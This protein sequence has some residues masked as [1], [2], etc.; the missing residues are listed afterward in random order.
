[1]GL[2]RRAL[3]QGGAYPAALN[4]ANEVAVGAFLR[5]EIGFADIT[6]TARRIVKGEV[7]GRVVV[8][9]I[10]EATQA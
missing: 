7:R 2:A 1:M 3:T 5:E 9:D 10:A 8:T 6:E 4:A